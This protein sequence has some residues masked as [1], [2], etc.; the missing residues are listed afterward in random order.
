M[1]T[2]GFFFDL[3]HGDQGFGERPLVA[4]LS[5]MLKIQNDFFSPTTS[6]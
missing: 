2:S 5:A 6:S 4:F 3:E 1:C